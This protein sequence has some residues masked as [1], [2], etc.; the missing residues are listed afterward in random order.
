MTSDDSVIEIYRE[1]YVEATHGCEH[2]RLPHRVKF[3]LTEREQLDN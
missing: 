1:S 2:E 3:F